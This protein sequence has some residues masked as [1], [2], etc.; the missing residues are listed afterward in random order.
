MHQLYFNL[1]KRRCKEEH[2]ITVGNIWADMEQEKAGDDWRNEA[3]DPPHFILSQETSEFQSQSPIVTSCQVLRYGQCKNTLLTPFSP[4]S[5]QPTWI[6]FGVWNSLIQQLC[7]QG[8]IWKWT[9]QATY[10]NGPSKLKHIPSD[11]NGRRY[12]CLWQVHKC[13]KRNNKKWLWGYLITY[14][15]LGNQ[16]IPVREAG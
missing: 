3:G 15:L 2:R 11:W 10:W 5:L 12:I 16:V 7:K 8:L 1:K 4:V 14:S 9:Q 6:R 13:T